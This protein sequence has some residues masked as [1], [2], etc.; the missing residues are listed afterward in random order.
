M[1]QEPQ[2]EPEEGGRVATGWEKRPP[3]HPKPGC[4]SRQS[5]PGMTP[6]DGALTLSLGG[7]PFCAPPAVCPVASTAPTA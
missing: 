1:S 2:L 5:S 3:L 4:L 6:S 7:E